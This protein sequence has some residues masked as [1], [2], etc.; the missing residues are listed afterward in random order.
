M[1]GI[2]SGLATLIAAVVLFGAGCRHGLT[3][4][5]R[6]LNRASFDF[7][8][9]QGELDLTEIDH[10]TRGVRGCGRQATYVEV[11]DARMKCT[12]IMNHQANAAAGAAAAG[13]E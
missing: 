1:T 7:N 11:C 2:R 6:L 5:E 3:P 9:A 8:C 4:N 12:W 10:K 13:Q